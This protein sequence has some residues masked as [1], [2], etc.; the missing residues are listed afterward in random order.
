MARTVSRSLSRWLPT[1]RRML[2][3]VG[4]SGIAD[5]LGVDRPAKDVCDFAEETQQLFASLSDLPDFATL[6]D[7]DQQGA[8]AAFVYALGQAKPVDVWRGVFDGPSGVANR[9]LTTPVVAARG[10]LGSEGAQ[11]YF[12]RMIAEV[13][14]RLCN[15]LESRPFDTDTLVVAATRTLTEQNQETQRLI[16]ELES[17][18]RPPKDDRERELGRQRLVA[19]SELSRSLLEPD[20]L[21]LRPRLH[22]TAPASIGADHLPFPAVITGDG[23]QGK[24]VLLGQLYDAHFEVRPVILILASQVPAGAVVSTPESLDAELGRAAYGLPKAPSLTEILTSSRTG[25]RPL[26]LLDTIDLILSDTSADAITQLMTLL[27]ELCDLALTCRAHEWDDLISPM[28]LAWTDLRLT[29]LDKDDIIDWVGAYLAT[30]DVP[31]DVAENFSSSVASAANDKSLREVLAVPLRLAM[32][33]RLYAGRG[34]LPADLSV[35]QLYSTYWDTRVARDRRGRRGQVA[36]E[37]EV[38]ALELAGDLWNISRTRFSDSV[39]ATTTTMRVCRTLLSEGILKAVAARFSFFHQTFAEYAVARY[40]AAH[41]STRDWKALE[42]ALTDGSAGHWGVATHLVVGP[43]DL[44]RFEEM[45]VHIPRTDVLGVR[46][47][48]RGA[49]ARP[50]QETG[51]LF[52]DLADSNPKG[53]IGAADLLEDAP[54]S[55]ISRVLTHANRW[56]ADPALQNGTLVNAVSSLILNS[57]EDK[58]QEHLRTALDGLLKAPSVELPAQSRRLL[59]L[60]FAPTNGSVPLPSV[61]AL[62]RYGVLPEPAR[63]E[64]IAVQVTRPTPGA[65]LEVLSAALAEACPTTGIDDAAALMLRCWHEP[66]SR[67]TLAWTSWRELLA[68]EYPPRWDAAQVRAVARISQGDPDVLRE[69]IAA[70]LA[71]QE[72]SR[73]RIHN[74]IHFLAE[75]IPREVGAVALATSADPHRESAGTF[76]VLTRTVAPAMEPVKRRELIDRL[77]QYAIHDGRRVWPALARAAVPDAALLVELLTEVA[78]VPDPRVRRSTL[79]TCLNELDPADRA[80]HQGALRALVPSPDPADREARARLDGYLALDDEQARAAVRNHL[81][82]Q[83]NA[84]EPLAAGRSLVE[85]LQTRELHLGPGLTT[86]LLDV[87]DSRHEHVVRTVARCLTERIGILHWDGVAVSRIL[88]RHQQ[89]LQRHEDAQVAAALKDMVGALLHA[90]ETELRALVTPSVVLLILDQY[91]ASLQTLYTN[92]TLRTQPRTPA[93][94]AQ[95]QQTV[96]GLAMSALPLQ[97]TETYLSRLLVDFDTSVIAGRS[98]R[99]LASTLVGF[100]ARHPT[101]WSAAVEAAWPQMPAANKAAVAECLKRGSVPDA[102]V[103]ARTLALRKDCPREVAEVLLKAFP[104]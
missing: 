95:I 32:A 9:L 84:K 96:T 25:Q 99:A 4:L 83:P 7:D 70:G 29:G 55:W 36:M 69:V 87:I 23:G 22:H 78:G 82:R 3:L 76:A 59:N 16:Q 31:P 10:D 73:E 37:Q 91:I 39:A 14:A 49:F 72:I 86:W 48:L 19:R 6:S 26:L 85:M 97:T 34:S 102:R 15:W 90:D 52:E 30:T 8:E 42:E 62:A 28:S 101:R 45:V 12:D 44:P 11:Q 13:S 77:R 1:V 51:S 24:S 98:F 41:G 5:A 103:R 27:A 58:R 20:V 56:L 64:V 18:V 63:A 65:D 60:V 17:L 104:E 66:E 94:Y 80:T 2:Y 71:H 46:L 53:L 47:L 92:P 89:A 54:S 68:N 57:H 35:T 38:A 40:L 88:A 93:L 67:D 74:A 81:A 61:V 79:E 33:C 100:S 21:P 43:M 75:E 50:P